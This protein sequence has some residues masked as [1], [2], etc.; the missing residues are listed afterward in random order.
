M[1][2][3]FQ[4]LSHQD[5]ESL[6]K[7]SS[8]E[9]AR[10]SRFEQLNH[11]L[12]QFDT[13]MVCRVMVDKLKEESLLN[14]VIFVVGGLSG[15]GKTTLARSM[16]NEYGALHVQADAVRKH[17]SGIP[18]NE[19][20]PADIYTPEISRETYRGMIE[21]VDA[22]IRAGMPVV[23]DGTYMAPYQRIGIE[24]L[25][26]EL[27]TPIEGFWLKTSL[28]NQEARVVGRVNSVSDAGIDVVKNMYHSHHNIAPH[29]WRLIDASGTAAQVLQATLKYV[30]SYL[31]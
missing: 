3:K 25:A 21:R 11:H 1:S 22:V 29:G 6:L 10:L 28:G 4:E 30:T 23:M 5:S 18:V 2:D 7:V 9:V 24:K 27:R 17:L 14:P 12:E 15:T 26:I 8:P 13:Y 20:G 31:K 19:R 16:A